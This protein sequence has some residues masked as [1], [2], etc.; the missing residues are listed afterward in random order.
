MVLAIMNGNPQANQKQSIH[1]IAIQNLIIFFTHSIPFCFIVACKIIT[2]AYLLLRT[3]WVKCCTRCQMANGL[4]FERML[5]Q[6]FSN[7][8]SWLI[9]FH[10][11]DICIEI[12]V[13]RCLENANFTSKLAIFIT[14]Y[15]LKFSTNVL[16]WTDF[17][18]YFHWISFHF[19]LFLSIWLFMNF[20]HFENYFLRHTF[21]IVCNEVS[22]TICIPNE[23]LC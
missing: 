2:T 10:L 23:F 20:N 13:K 7:A 19:Y 6:L 8:V 1:F 15:A 22:Y 5:F 3:H 17:Y 16:K 21:S 9:D 14:S 11:W 12:E 4:W 18:I